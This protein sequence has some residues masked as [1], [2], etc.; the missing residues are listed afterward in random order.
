MEASSPNYI[1]KP[2]PIHPFQSEKSLPSYLIPLHIETIGVKRWKGQKVN[3]QLCLLHFCRNTVLSW[4]FGSISSVRHLQFDQS[5]SGKVRKASAF[6]NLPAI[7]Y[8]FSQ[9]F[10]QPSSER[11]VLTCYMEE[12][13]EKENFLFV[14]TISPFRLIFLLIESSHKQ[15]QLNHGTTNH[16]NW[17]ETCGGPSRWG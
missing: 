12:T 8:V 1:H 2:Q 4:L 3:F 13:I 17:D 5:Q 11:Q 6:T 15:T 16:R 14:Q 10:C 9:N 7:I